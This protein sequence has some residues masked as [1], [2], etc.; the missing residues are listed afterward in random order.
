MIS[1]E[2][3]FQ[4]YKGKKFIAVIPAR[5]GSKGIP[6][7]NIIDVN[8]KPLIQYSIEAAQQSKYIDKIFV[9]TDS[10]KIANVAIKCGINVPFLRPKELATDTSKT[11]DVLVDLVNRFKEQNEYFD[12]LVLLQPTQPLRQY[13]HIDQAIE[14][15]VNTNV[16]S[17]VSV[18]KVKDHPI[19][20]R[21]IDEDGLLHNLINTN[22]TVR[23]QDF[24]DFYKVN[25]AIY[26]N[27]L[28]E[29]FNLNTSLNDNKLAFI[30][31]EKYD[32]DIDNM[33]DLKI[34]RLLLADEGFKL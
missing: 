21:T 7:K 3:G 12:Y 27:K 11:I 29:T 25:G 34:C 8:G 30:M 20:V 14:K 2:G 22:S 18:S 31:D 23:R 28:D 24:Q 16:N 32:L 4:M 26:I 15:I 19:L 33:L 6:D 13:F 9:S 10:E 17:L 1:I 5:G